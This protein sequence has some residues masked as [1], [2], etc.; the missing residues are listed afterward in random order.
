MIHMIMTEHSWNLVQNISKVTGF[1][2]GKTRP[3]PM[4]EEEAER[5]L[6]IVETRQDDPRPKFSFDR[7]EEV[8]IMDG[9]FSGF[10]GIVDDVNYD[11]GKLRVSV[12]I[13]GRQTPVEL[14]FVQV[15]KG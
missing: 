11:K 7:G 3:A 4:K 10:N 13:F 1:L 6:S 2:G 5:I 8:R 14:D 9:P 15:S 12:S